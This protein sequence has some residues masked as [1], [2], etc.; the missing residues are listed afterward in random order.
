MFFGFPG[1]TIVAPSRFH[2]SGV[3]LEKVIESREFTLIME[4]KLLYEQEVLSPTT[5]SRYEGFELLRK[6]AGIDETVVL[7]PCEDG[8]TPMIT[9]V[10]YGG[11]SSAVFS[12]ARAVFMQEEITCEIVIP[13]TVKPLRIDE[14]VGSAR[15]SGRV[16]I[17]E[18]THL[19]W[20]WGAEVVARIVHDCFESLRCPVARLAAKD[21]IIPCARPL[22]DLVLPQEQEIIVEL[23]RLAEA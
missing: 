9:I 2:D 4:H 6:G 1:V 13:A 7:S 22:E 11:I 12:A 15:Q 5:D 16:L 20:G 14:I 17:V 18:E 8:E 23:L 21:E 10:T 19:S 3:L